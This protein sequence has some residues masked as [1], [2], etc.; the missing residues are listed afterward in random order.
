MISFVQYMDDMKGIQSDTY[1]YPKFGISSD[2][3]YSKFQQ[4][5]DFINLNNPFY[6][7][8]YVFNQR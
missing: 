8:N 6:P 3:L 5:N 1:V 2:K 4:S 7:I